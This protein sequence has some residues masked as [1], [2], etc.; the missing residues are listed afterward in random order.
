M[1]D[2]PLLPL[3]SVQPVAAPLATLCFH[4]FHILDFMF[5]FIPDFPRLLYFLSL[6]CR[7]VCCCGW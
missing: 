6:D 2:P 7:R 5:Y 4:V 1:G 3:R